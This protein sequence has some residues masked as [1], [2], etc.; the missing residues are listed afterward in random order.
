[1]RCWAA[2]KS[3]EGIWKH[4][5]AAVGGQSGLELV[6]DGLGDKQLWRR[7]MGWNVIA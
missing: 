3:A 1:M 7:E 2:A 4:W 6:E 5:E